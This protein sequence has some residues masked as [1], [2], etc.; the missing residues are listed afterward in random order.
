MSTDSQHC[1]KLKSDFEMKRK[2]ENHSIDKRNC[3]RQKR[4]FEDGKI[5]GIIT[6]PFPL[7]FM[8]NNYLFLL[9]SNGCLPKCCR[10]RAAIFR[11]SYIA[12][13]ERVDRVI[14]NI[15]QPQTTLRLVDDRRKQEATTQKPI[16]LLFSIGISEGF[17][18]DFMEIH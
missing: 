6:I 4:M 14:Y 11:M 15:S 12:A 18:S 3:V 7:I 2:K 9:F 13:E 5:S 1:H 17:N 10:Q 8:H 16:K